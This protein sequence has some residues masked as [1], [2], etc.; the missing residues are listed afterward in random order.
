MPIYKPP[1][2]TGIIYLDAPLTDWGNG[3]A[4]AS[5]PELSIPDCYNGRIDASIPDWCNDYIQASISDSYN[6]YIDTF[7][8][9]WCNEYIGVSIQACNTLTSTYLTGILAGKTPP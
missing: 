7:V 5:I 6:G 1:Y 4:D 9:L 3:Y 2:L 8:T